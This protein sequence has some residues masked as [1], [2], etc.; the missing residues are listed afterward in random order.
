MDTADPSV[1]VCLVCAGNICRSPMAEAIIRNAV[2]QRDL[3][4][5]VGSRGTGAW[6]QGSN[7]DPR[8]LKV[9]RQHGL[10]LAGHRAQRF[11]DND[12]NYYDVILVM[13][14]ENYVDI[15]S[16]VKDGNLFAKV[17][18]Y[19]EFAEKDMK[20]IEVPDPYFAD[21]TVFEEVFNLLASSADSVVERIIDEL[22]Y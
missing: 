18:L 22:A 5:E 1:K 8:T 2:T 4:W 16:R 11:S 3:R 7:A 10:E 13:D 17:H 21:K 15:T 12:F 6:H 19:L 9:L 20:S 14:H